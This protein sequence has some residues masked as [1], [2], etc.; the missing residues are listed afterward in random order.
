MEMTTKEKIIRKSIK[1]VEKKITQLEEVRDAT[2]GSELIEIMM[3]AQRLFD[4]NKGIEK[5][6]SPLFLKKIKYLAEK[7]DKCRKMIARQRNWEKDCNTLVRYEIELSDLKR[8]LYYI[9]QRR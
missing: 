4:Q 3:S 7:E 8:E 2:P 6:T 9:E 5:R 1:E